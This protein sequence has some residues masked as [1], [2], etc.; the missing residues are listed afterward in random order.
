M[1]ELVTASW[2]EHTHISY[3]PYWISLALAHTHAMISFVLKEK[4]KQSDPTS[5]Q[6]LSHFLSSFLP[7]SLELTPIKLLTPLLHQRQLSGSAVIS[8]LLNPIIR[9]HT[10]FY[11]IHQQPST[12]LFFPETLASRVCLTGRSLSVSFADPASSTGPLY[13]GLVFSLCKILLVI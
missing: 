7:F 13:V 12:E 9:S 6:L 3:S 4:R 5:L 2:C 1:S 8:A 10:L 11:L